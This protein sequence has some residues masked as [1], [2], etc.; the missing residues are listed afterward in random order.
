MAKFSLAS[1]T[2]RIKDRVSKRYI[3]LDNFDKGNDLFDILNLYLDKL[4]NKCSHDR[5]HK[6]LLRVSDLNSN[7]RII[8]GIIETGEYGYEATLFDTINSSVSYERKNYEAEFLPFYFLIEIPKKF[9]EGII[10]LQ[11][12]KQ[13]GIRKILLDRFNRFFNSLHPNFAI[14]INPLIPEGLVTQY[15]DEGRITKIRF[16]KFSIPEDLADFYNAQDHLEK[17]GYTE[18][19]ICARRNRSIPILSPI[20]EYLEKKRKLKGVIEIQGFKYDNVKIEVE[21]GKNHR[22]IDLGNLDRIRPYFDITDEVRVSESGHPS[23]DSINNIAKSLLKDF[24]DSMR[25]NSND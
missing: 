12:F 2:L 3:P 25:G 8:N 17:E 4:E 1:Y 21:I 24:S 18:L 20:R 13:Y 11:R 22:T 6:R 9:D 16:I 5:E 7:D 14:E 15:L 19:V 23:F 10:M